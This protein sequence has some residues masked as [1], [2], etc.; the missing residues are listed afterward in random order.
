MLRGREE[1]VPGL[2]RAGAPVP[3][4]PGD[5]GLIQYG[6][7]SVFF[8]YTTP[9]SALERKQRSR[10]LTP[11]VLFWRLLTDDPLVGLSLFSSIVFHLG[12]IGLL[13][14]NWTPDEYRLPP[15]LVSPEDY[16]ALFGLKRVLPE[17]EPVAPS[18]DDKTGG[19]KGVKDPGAKDP[20][21]QGGG[22]KIVGKEGKAGPK[23][24][25]RPLRAP[26]RDQAHHELRRPERSA[27]RHR[28]GHQEDAEPRSR[29]SPT[30]SAASTRT[31]S[32]SGAARAR[33][34]TARARAAAAR[35]R[36]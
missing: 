35:A 34:C 12:L 8:Q 32:S 33:G 4:L 28:D 15:E 26:G 10:W 9:A 31:T 6:L 30:R 2:A 21:K 20:K 3:V 14:I 24:Q 22:Q 29:P 36:A 16:A 13:I 11:F 7:F 18:K 19:G 1:N 27:R 17:M 23:R 25:G 5:Y